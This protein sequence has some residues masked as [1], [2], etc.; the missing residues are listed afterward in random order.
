MGKRGIHITLASSFIPL[1][2]INGNED[3]YIHVHAHDIIPVFL[4]LKYMGMRNDIHIH[5]YDIDSWYM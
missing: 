1:F 2:F 5:V 4:S 3:I